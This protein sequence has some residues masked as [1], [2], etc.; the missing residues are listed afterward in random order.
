[1]EASQWAEFAGLG[2][3][4]A[5]LAWAVYRLTGVL[6]RIFDRLFPDHTTTQP[7]PELEPVEDEWP[8]DDAERGA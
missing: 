7:E 3:A 4:L 8:D 5:V 2:F 6:A 1:M